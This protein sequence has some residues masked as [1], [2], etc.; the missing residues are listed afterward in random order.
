MIIAMEKLKRGQE[1]RGQDFEMGQSFSGGEDA[2]LRGVVK[3]GLTE[4]ETSRPGL[5]EV[6]ESSRHPRQVF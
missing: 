4:K 1:K 3:V 2:F 5:K 6:R